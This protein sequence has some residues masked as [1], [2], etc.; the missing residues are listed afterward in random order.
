MRYRESQQ[1]R[2]LRKWFVSDMEK[3]LLRSV[4]L[5]KGSFR[6][7]NS[8]RIQFDYPI[9]A[10]CGKNGAGKSTITALTC[11]AFHGLPHGYRLPRRRHTYYTFSDFFIQHPSESSQND[12]AIEY[13]IATNQWRKSAHFPDGVGL[14]FQHRKKQRG[15]KWNDYDTRVN[16]TV[17]FLGIERVVPHTE[18]SQS[19]SYLRAF[20][21]VPLKGWENQVM[22]HVGY[23][24][25]KS[26]EEFRYVVHTKY[27]LPIVRSGAHAYSGFNMGAGENA[28]FDIF[29]TIYSAGSG[30]LIVVDEIELGLHVEAQRKLIERL[31]EVCL[32]QKVQIVCTTHSKEVLEALPPD[33]RYFV[34]SINGKSSVTQGISSAFAF[35][36]LSSVHGLE[37]ELLVEDEVAQAIT[38]AVLPADIRTRVSVKVIGSVKALCRQLSA[39]YRRQDGRPVVA[40]FDGDQLKVFDEN[41]SYA[42]SMAENVSEDFDN[43]FD[44][45]SA[46]LAGESWPEKWLI[47]RALEI[48][49]TLSSILRIAPDQLIES[50]RAAD[51]AGKHHEI[52]TLAPLIGLEKSA[53]LHLVASAVTAE[54]DDEFTPLVMRVTQLL[55]GHG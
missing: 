40:I 23:I 27:S 32:S 26:Y 21:D 10:I 54:F 48:P 37:G 49:K 52:S 41:R 35:S 12:V 46:H 51:R 15:G 2:R 42:R 24:L 36:K 53:C 16:R 39:A 45:H 19:R 50:L 43:W 34:E 25:G 13:G 38:T 9:A 7:L 6:S 14:G 8:L 30:A 3:S 5:L 29:S 1:D 17:V 18:R 22:T 4:A 31:K 11:C 44:N 28:L 20:K 55:D 33:A 47:S